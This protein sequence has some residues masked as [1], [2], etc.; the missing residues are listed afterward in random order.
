MRGLLFQLCAVVLSGG[1]AIAASGAEPNEP[2]L[3]L[4]TADALLEPEGLAP[5]SVRVRLDFRWDDEFP[6][7]D[8]RAR[9]R[10]E[11]PAAAP[12]GEPM[13]LLFS[14]IGN[15]A[16]IRVNDSL[17]QSLGTL[18][19]ARVDAAKSSQLVLVPAALLSTG[20]RNE[21]VI[22]STVQHQR[23]GGLSE[24]LYGPQRAIEPVYLQQHHQRHTA[25]V[26]YAVSLALMG[27]LSAGLWW[28]QRDALYG[29][30]SLAALF[31]VARYLDRAGFDA[32][33]P[34]PW[35]G[36]A[37]AVAYA[38]HLGLIARFVLLVL[39][40]GPAWLIRAIHGA[41]LAAV[42]LGCLSFVLRAPVLWN[43]GLA[44][45]V[46]LGATL[47][48]AVL[49]QALA[50][51]SRI[52]W[53]LF[54]AGALA[55]A[56]GTHDLLTVR[57]GLLSGGG[58]T[59]VPH[60]VFFFVLVLAGLVVERYSR[61][62]S[63]YRALNTTLADRVAARERQLQETFETLRIERERQ[64]VLVERQRLMRDMHDGVGSQLVGLLNVV[65]RGDARADVV[66][67]HV[68]QALDEMRMVVDS[69]Q[70][71]HADL[72]VML[73]TLRYRM[74][75]RLAAAGIELAWQ[76]D[77]LP[78]LPQPSPQVL[79]QV[80]RILLEAFTNVLKHARAT[81][82]RFR[83]EWCAGPTPGLQL[84]LSDNGVGIAGAPDDAEAAPRAGRGL[85]N[86]QQRARAIGA[87][88]HIGHGASGGTCIRLD[89][90]QPAVVA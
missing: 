89:W 82:I 86:M 7:L 1:L 17:I 79:L 67:E 21:L 9:Y 59:L 20:H 8:G 69:L 34:W 50:Q 30:F 47:L 78:E 84:S 75:P 15:Q 28:R 85:G 83:A 46:L 11:L 43:G 33:V 18:G 23:G 40:L 26:A 53:I 4:D 71:T 65:H 13:A 81:E 57:L 52:A 42:V 61:T 32:P 64:A 29:C 2:A 10:L 3:T 60:A 38:L 68:R 16:T 22:D 41:T 5:R 55:F 19:S 39:G 35:W 87:T 14:R 49:R 27:A 72:T 76:M 51:R 12:N 6:G 37:V 70:P 74:Q 63:D 80:Q 25:L 45:L 58:H 54:A 62:L 77:R 31:G 56:A 24:V 73:A 90:P 48:P 88:L 66:E 44:L 36:G